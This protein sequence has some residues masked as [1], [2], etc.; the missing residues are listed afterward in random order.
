M[1]LDILL[2]TEEEGYTV[3]IDGRT[4]RPLLVDSEGR[5]I[6][7]V[8]AHGSTHD[9]AGSDPLS[10]ESIISRKLAPTVVEVQ[11]T[12]N[13]TI[14]SATDTDITGA[15]ITLTPAIASMAIVIGVFGWE[16]PSDTSHWVGL[17]DVDGANEGAQSVHTSNGSGELR[18]ATTQIWVVPLTAA[19]HTL[20]LQALRGGGTGTIIV[21]DANTKLVV[22]LVGDA[23]VTQV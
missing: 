7:T 1:P 6:T 4:Y 17:L 23:Y 22:I 20:K 21:G 5:L 3:V 13:T 11:A 19:S 14:N 15:T 18:A 10:D 16:D 8:A 9:P 12:A 2:G